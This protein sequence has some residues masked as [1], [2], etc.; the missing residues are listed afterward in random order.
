MSCASLFSTYFR[1]DVVEVDHIITR[2]QIP[3]IQTPSHHTASPS[4]A[5][6]VALFK[7]I[8]PRRYI[9]MESVFH[10]L[11]TFSLLGANFSWRVSLTDVYFLFFFTRT[12]SWICEVFNT[13]VYLLRKAWGHLLHGDYLKRVPPWVWREFGEPV[14]ALPT[15]ISP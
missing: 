13:S 5:I 14:I 1:A 4:L 3:A 2:L 11:D 7:L 12:A 8:F 15:F 6:L 10:R 9:D